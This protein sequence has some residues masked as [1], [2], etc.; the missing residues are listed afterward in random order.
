[1]LMQSNLGGF[2]GAFDD[3]LCAL[4]PGAEEMIENLLKQDDDPLV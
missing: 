1:M 2:Y 4:G 3:Y